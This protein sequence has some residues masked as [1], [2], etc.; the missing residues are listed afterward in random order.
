M[1]VR[2][3]K[4]RRAS[5]AGGTAR[6]GTRTVAPEWAWHFRTLL[7]LRNHL[8]SGRGEPGGEP[9]EAMEPPS[10]HALDV[11]AD[12]YDRDLALALPADREVAL[13]EVNDALRRIERGAY[14]ICEATGKPIAR[15]RLKAAP[16]RRYTPLAARQRDRV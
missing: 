13:R 15:S 10:L 1:T 12:V 5:A 8:L 6:P 16:W 3:A 14:G 2:K 4:L 7:A 11:T 9:G